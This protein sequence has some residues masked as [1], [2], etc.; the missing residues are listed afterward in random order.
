MKVSTLR[1]LSIS[2]LIS[3]SAAFAA[4]AEAAEVVP[5]DGNLLCTRDFNAWGHASQCQCPSGSTYEKRSAYCLKGEL[6][7]IESVGAV[8]T[9]V[10]AIGGETTGIVLQSSEQDMYELILP[11]RIQKELTESEANGT[12]YQVQGDYLEVPGVETGARPTIIVNSLSPISDGI[13]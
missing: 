1:N 2:A 3:M 13:R 9:E 8:S 7:A 12:I 5:G 4:T 10:S 6:E 11:L